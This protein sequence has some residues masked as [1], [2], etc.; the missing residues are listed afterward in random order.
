LRLLLATLLWLG[1]LEVARA[2]TM[3][4]SPPTPVVVDAPRGAPAQFTI[5]VEADRTTNW[6]VT[7]MPKWLKVDAGFGRTPADVT[8]TVNPDLLREGWSYGVTL[9]FTNTR[10][11]QGDTARAVAV[12]VRPAGWV[13]PVAGGFLCADEVGPSGR[14]VERLLAQ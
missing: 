11:H 10:N 9:Q 2:Q 14:C 1:A 5:K 8:F 13:A 6:F 7:G 3:T 4:V 12:M